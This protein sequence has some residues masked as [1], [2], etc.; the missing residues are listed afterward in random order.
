MSPCLP[1]QFIPSPAEPGPAKWH[2]SEYPPASTSGFSGHFSLWFRV[3]LWPLARG[4]SIVGTPS[5]PSHTGARQTV[6]LPPGWA[7]A[8]LTGRA[9]PATRVPTKMTGSHRAGINWPAKHTST[10]S[11]GVSPNGV[12]SLYHR[13][14][15]QMMCAHPAVGHPY[16]WDGLTCQTCVHCVVGHP[17]GWPKLVNQI[18]PD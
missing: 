7:S 10:V 6:R 17:L 16:G 4:P 8:Y 14:S 9:I 2:T 5:H 15:A 18:G 1:R 12:R 13:E 3:S 11:S